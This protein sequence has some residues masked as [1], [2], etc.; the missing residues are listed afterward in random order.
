MA[1]VFS[2][3]DLLGSKPLL[4]KSGNVTAT[5]LASLDVV[6]FYFSAHWCPPCR[7]FTPEF[8]AAYEA[9]PAGSNCEI[10]FVSADNDEDT[11]KSYHSEMPW[12]ALDY[13]E[14]D[15]NKALSTKFGVTGYPM[16]VLCD[17]KTGAVITSK[18]RSV[19]SK[20]KAQFAIEAP[21]LGAK[22][23]LAE[24]KVQDLSILGNNVTRADGSKVTTAT[25]AALDTI[26]VAFGNPGNAGWAQYVKPKL[27]AAYKELK[28]EKTIGLFGGQG[29][30]FEVVYCSEDAS[31][32]KSGPWCFMPSG[33]SSSDFGALGDMG[34]PNVVVLSRLGTVAGKP[35]KLNVFK[36]LVDDASR[37]VYEHGA[38]AYPWDEAGIAAA[39]AKKEAKSKEKLKQMVDMKLLQDN[40]DF[41][42]AGGTKIALADIRKDAD[43]I[44]LYFSAHWCGPCR[45]FTPRLAA[46]YKECQ[47]ANKRFDII[48]I[49]SDRDQSSFDSYFKEMPWKALAY[50]KRDLKGELSEMYG[51]EGIPS[52]VL[53]KADGTEITRSGREIVGVGAE[54]FPWGPAEMAA[55]KKAAAEKAA[56]AAL[57]AAKKEQDDIAAAK[58]D[59][60][61][62]FNRFSGEVGVSPI[63]RTGSVY[64]IQFNAF[65]SFVSEEVPAAGKRYY[66][67]E[68]VS[69]GQG[70]AQVGFADEKF[71]AGRGSGVGDD[72]HSWGFDGNRVCKWG[73][74]T[75]AKYGKA[76]SDGDVLGCAIDFDA[77]QVSFYLNGE[78]MGIAFD[79]IE[80]TGKLRVAASAQGNSYKLKFNFGTTLAFPAPAGYT[81]FDAA[82]L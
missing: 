23:A 33:T 76:W 63:N 70:I 62:I 37:T 57:V 81:T 58:A 79:G 24:G 6:G 59:G 27:L 65:D 7:S 60:A 74:A 15:V 26:V 35:V 38:A 34:S 82:L 8:A 28:A 32:A 53:L 67:I 69:V 17:A 52:L 9:M 48:F 71:S 73:N 50:S 56:K 44:A 13:N 55:G 40:D 31:E 10:V 68:C 14:K 5:S 66:E 16:V 64:D 22:K 36:I 11:F 4:K 61:F 43:V 30:Q 78:T 47:A 21:K 80:F 42:G 46:M 49:S 2:W 39:A 51:V 25:L 45:G 75:Q 3:T 20:H 41:V 29:P 72:K 54:Y 18:G 1:S 19:V 12:A 77:K